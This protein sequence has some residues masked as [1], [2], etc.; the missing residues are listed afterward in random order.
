MTHDD[1]RL[2]LFLSSIGLALSIFAAGLC[3]DLGADGEKWAF[4]LL[5]L[6]SLGVALR[7]HRSLRA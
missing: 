5:A 4:V 6:L 3:Y 7:A 1:K 2:A